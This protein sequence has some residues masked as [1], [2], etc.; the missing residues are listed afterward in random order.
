MATFKKGDWVQITPRPDPYWQHWNSAHDA[1]V[2]MIGRI[3]EMEKDPDDGALTFV[4]VL[5]YDESLDPLMQEWFLERHLILSTRYD[6]VLEDELHKA[7][8][9]LQKWEAK[10]KNMVDDSLRK[11]FGY[12]TEEKEKPKKKTKKK[13]TS[14]LE[15]SHEEDCEKWEDDTEEI[16]QCDIDIIL[17]ELEEMDGFDYDQAWKDPDGAD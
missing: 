16:L 17:E 4:Q 7:C 14:A 10:K 2:G 8:D 1:M 5:I 6:K 15:V 3:V 9:E 12:E 13:S 11:A